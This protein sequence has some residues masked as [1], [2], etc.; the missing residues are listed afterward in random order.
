MSQPTAARLVDTLHRAN[1]FS[2]EMTGESGIGIVADPF[3]VAATDSG[4]HVLFEVLVEAEEASLS[5]KYIG[6]ADVAFDRNTDALRWAYRGPAIR[7]GRFRFAFPYVF[8]FNGETYCLPDITDDRG[9]PTP[10]RLYRRSGDAWEFLQE[11]DVSGSDPVVFE[12]GGQWWLCAGKVGDAFGG[13]R[14]YRARTPLEFG[15]REPRV[16]LSARHPLTRMA[17]RPLV[18]D[19]DVWLPFQFRPRGEPYGV[20]CRYLPLGLGASKASLHRWRRGPLVT[21][22][23]DAAWFADGVHHLE[24]SP[25]RG[26][27]LFDGR[28]AD[29][30]DEWRIGAVRLAPNEARFFLGRYGHERGIR[31][32]GR[33]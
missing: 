2:F 23:G 3:V 17:G 15:V 26:L 7:D 20:A 4:A 16:V 6:S 5:S 1:V 24:L 9:R 27:L 8:D 31:A 28:R 13:V 19:E 33:A 30:E 12:Q 22:A 25:D 32:G 18:A 10:L 29:R 21:G 14:L 11:F